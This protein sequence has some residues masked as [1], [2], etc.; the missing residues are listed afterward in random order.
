MPRLGAPRG[1][2]DA[3]A[4]FAP[5]ADY[6]RLALAV[7]GGAD[8]L[9]LML[10]AHRFA[11]EAGHGHD[12]FFVYSVDHGLRPEAAAEAEFVVREARRLGFAA[13]ILRWDDEKPET[14]IQ[15]AARLARYR[16]F[17]AAM[18]ADGAA[19]LLTAHHLG[20]QAETVLMRLAHGSGVEGLRGMDYCS[21]IEGLTIVRPLLGVDP[22]EL[23]CVVEMAGLTPVVDPSNSDAD[24]ERVRWRQVMP[25]LA[26]LGLDAR[27]LASF[28]DRMRDAD[29]AL[30]NMAAQ[31]FAHVEL[32][33]DRS[34]AAIDRSLLRHL[35]RA[36]AVRVVARTL[37]TVGGSRK[38]HALAAVEALTDRLIREPVRTTLH[39]CIVRSG[40]A[41]VRISREPERGEAARRRKKEPSLS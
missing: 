7:S 29:R 27:R 30:L 23:R 6:P 22:E 15:Q 4:V 41:S 3:R 12:R 40:R 17:A 18:A 33:P 13:R 10:L 36:I 19:A 8:S 5:L 28:A 16:L 31:A 9:A 14:G 11:Q 20:D 1:A 24:Y 26:A 39:G 32:A 34:E 2:I 38:P 21:E 35:P 25:Q 37:V